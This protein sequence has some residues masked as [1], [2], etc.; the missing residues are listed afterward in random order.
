MFPSPQEQAMLNSM[1]KELQSGVT[2]HQFGLEK[3]RID[4]LR[5]Q[6]NA[7]ENSTIRADL[8]EQ[9]LR[10]RRFLGKAISGWMERV[11]ELLRHTAHAG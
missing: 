4:E 1:R 5:D 3:L 9:T 6:A 7:I 11:R 8:H 2:P 10:S